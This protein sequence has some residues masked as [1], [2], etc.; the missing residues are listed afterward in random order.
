MDLRVDEEKYEYAIL[1]RKGRIDTKKLNAIHRPADS[2]CVK[3]Q[4]SVSLEGV[5]DDTDLRRIMPIDLS[6]QEDGE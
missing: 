2:L 6:E 3:V 1:T 5:G 4:E